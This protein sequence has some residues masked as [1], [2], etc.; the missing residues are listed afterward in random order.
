MMKVVIE[1]DAYVDRR[2]EIIKH[3]VKELP[4]DTRSI[5]EVFDMG[6]NFNVLKITRVMLKE[7]D[8]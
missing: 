5:I 6:R 2:R 1:Y 4:Y 3:K 7:S 8:K